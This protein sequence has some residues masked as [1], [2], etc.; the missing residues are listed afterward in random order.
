MANLISNISNVGFKTSEGGE[1][2]GD[3]TI[4]KGMAQHVQGKYNIPDNTSADIVG[5]GTSDENRSNAYT[6]DWEGNGWY[7]GDVYVG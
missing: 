3:G 1:I 6:L 2:F 4:S 7:S 5:N